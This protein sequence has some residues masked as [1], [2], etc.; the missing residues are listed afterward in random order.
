MAERIAIAM[1]G[2]V[3]S[4]VAAAL[5][6]EQGYE[7]VGLTMQIWPR[8]GAEDGCPGATGC[9][10]LD[11]LDDARR[12][13]QVLGIRHYVMD[14][15]EAFERLVIEPFCEHYLDGLTP[16]P[17]ILCNTYLKYEELLRRAQEIGATHLATGHYARVEYD[18]GRGRWLLRRAAD[19]SKDQTYALYDL[20][21]EQ[22]A[23]ALFPLGGVTKTE[24]RQRA[25]A[26][27][28]PVAEK[29]DSQQ[30]CF[31]SEGSYGEYVAR[32]RPGAARPGPIV[33]R[34][35]RQVG[36]HRGVLHYTVG[37]RQGLGISHR[38]PLYVVEIDAKGNRL[39][40]GEESDLEASE[41]TME[42]VNYVGLASLLAHGQSLL[43]KIR[44]TAEPAP[45][46]A[47]PV[48]DRVRVVFSR[49][50]RAI[51]PGQAAVCYDSDLLAFGGIITSGA[52]SE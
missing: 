35:G 25:A 14:L 26:L 41:L 42:R 15:R 12:V 8:E 1:S 30:I 39:V 50:L 5:L 22:L 34:W 24:T 17:C 19:E 29:P 7:V 18:G 45:C 20:S 44:Y 6:V 11:A 46:R 32:L 43:V 9:C 51:T 13:A 37:Q 48:G 52:R 27:G 38:R 31:V 21:Q 40:V 16:N 33:D 49:P 10:G 3:D 28:L 23:K 47:I 2:G 36:R 4:S